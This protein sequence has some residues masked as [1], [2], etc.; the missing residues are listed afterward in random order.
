MS[1]FDNISL[2]KFAELV[3]CTHTIHKKSLVPNGNYSM[4]YESSAVKAILEVVPID[5]LHRMGSSEIRLLTEVVSSA[6]SLSEFYTWADEV[7][8]EG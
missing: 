7:K 3:H 2:K 4:S 1:G 8:K 5:T 6:A